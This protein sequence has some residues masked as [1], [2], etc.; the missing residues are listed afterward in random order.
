[1][2]TLSTDKKTAVI[3]ALVEGC[4]IRSTERMTGV[5][6]DSIMRLVTETGRKAEALMADQI[7]H[8]HCERLE[9]DEIWSFVQKKKAQLRP[10]DDMTR[11]GDAWTWIALDPDSK[12]VPAHHVGRRKSQDAEALTKQLS[13]R[14]EGRVQISTDKLYAYRFAIALHL[15][16]SIHGNSKVDYGRIVKRYR[17]GPL[18]SGR[19]S[20]PEVVAIDK[21]AVFGNPDPDYICTSH[22]ERYNLH[23][24]TTMRRFTRLTLG[25]SKKIENLRAATALSVAHYNFCRK[26]STIKA[27]PAEVAGV[28]DHRWSLEEMVEAPY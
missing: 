8:V 20:P 17:G 28:S 11:V 13:E 23:L 18:D 2:A 21:D 4:S 3:G 14:I 7:R 26:H 12:L 5:H 15:G 6:R 25:F 27:T 1:M 16:G 19:Y 9:L 22:V 24:R 10:E